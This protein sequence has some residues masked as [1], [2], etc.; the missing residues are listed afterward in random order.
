MTLPAGKGARL[1]L[2]ENED[3]V[4]AWA[5]DAE[6]FRRLTGTRALATRIDHG[7][8]PAPDGYFKPSVLPETA[9]IPVRKGTPAA[10]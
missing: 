9:F 1:Y 7:G 4:R 3:G 2:F 5:A 6:D 10:V 8:V